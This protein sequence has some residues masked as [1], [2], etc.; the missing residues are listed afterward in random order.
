MSTVRLGFTASATV[1]LASNAE[2]VVKITTGLFSAPTRSRRNKATA[3]SMEKTRSTTRN[4][5]NRTSSPR[6]KPT[7]IAVTRTRVSTQRHV[8]ATRCGPSGTSCHRATAATGT[9]ATPRK[10]PSTSTASAITKPTHHRRAAAAG[11]DAE[12]RRAPVSTSSA[13]T[14]AAGI[15]TR[16]TARRRGITSFRAR[17]R[18]LP[19]MRSLLPASTTS[20]CA[21]HRESRSCRPTNH[22]AAEIRNPANVYTGANHSISLGFAKTKTPTKP[23]SIAAK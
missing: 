7:E 4:E 22:Q 13:S 1:A 19:P 9:S 6:A 2:V 8:N 18:P 10:P 15:P 3:R 11:I 16:K 12:A 14:W 23:A 17:R 21:A 5:E 20:C